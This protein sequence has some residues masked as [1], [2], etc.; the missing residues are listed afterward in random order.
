MAARRPNSLALP[1]SRSEHECRPFE[2]DPRAHSGEDED[3]P[4][5]RTTQ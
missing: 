3:G 4:W 1:A 2:E 5:L